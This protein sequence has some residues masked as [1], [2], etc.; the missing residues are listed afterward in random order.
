MIRAKMKCQSITNDT[1]TK[2]TVVQLYAEEG[3]PGHHMGVVITR[4]TAAFE[5]GKEYVVF[6]AT[7]EEAA[8]TEES[9][10]DAE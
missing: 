2:A 3:G 5:S 10:P 1:H 7:P 6:I 9:K 4:P 8:A